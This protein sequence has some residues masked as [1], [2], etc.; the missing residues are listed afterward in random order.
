[1]MTFRDRDSEGIVALKNDLSLL[2]VDLVVIA[3]KLGI[4]FVDASS[5][6]AANQKS[7]LLALDKIAHL[8]KSLGCVPKR[9]L[10]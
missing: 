5:A 9:F 7:I 2:G 10:K 6:P 8:T 3:K 4:Y 1:M